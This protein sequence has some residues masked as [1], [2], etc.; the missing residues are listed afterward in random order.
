MKDS[1]TKI[2]KPLEIKYK[3][4]AYY[5]IMS[6]NETIRSVEKK[7]QNQSDIADLK[8]KLYTL[9]KISSK[10]INELSIKNNMLE[11]NINKGSLL[12][13]NK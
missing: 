6:D 4:L 13:P 8:Q 3:I 11:S 12:E 2:L 9:D 5:I 7:S 1:L 10:M